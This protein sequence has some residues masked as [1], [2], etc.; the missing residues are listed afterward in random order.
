MP[1]TT[2]DISTG[3]NHN[4]RSADAS[5]ARA[6]RHSASSNPPTTSTIVATIVKS[7]VLITAFQNTGSAKSSAAKLA[8]PANSTTPCGLMV[9][10]AL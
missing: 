9:W 2:Y 10:K 4:T 1:T 5:G 7:A 3:V 8:S 6:K